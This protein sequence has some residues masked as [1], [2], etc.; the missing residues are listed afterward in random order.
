METVIHYIKPNGASGYTKAKST[1]RRL[2][3]VLRSIESKGNELT[4][5]AIPMVGTLTGSDIYKWIIEN[6]R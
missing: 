1:G 2:A 6:S 3:G 4:S 5:V